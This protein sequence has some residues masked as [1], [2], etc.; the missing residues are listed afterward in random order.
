MDN[1]AK[2]FDSKPKKVHVHEH[3]KTMQK[4]YDEEMNKMAKMTAKLERKQSEKK[5]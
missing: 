5:S 1:V 2:E 3:Y 4:N